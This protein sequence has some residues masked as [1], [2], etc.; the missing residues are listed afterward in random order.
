MKI[1]NSGVIASAFSV[2]SV[3]YI[4]ICEFVPLP[5]S[6]VDELGLS[7]WCALIVINCLKSNYSK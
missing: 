3:C 4:I 1:G 7:S 2:F 6:V 5:C